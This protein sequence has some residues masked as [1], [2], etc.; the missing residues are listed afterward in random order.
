M[1]EDKITFRPD[2]VRV[3]WAWECGEETGCLHVGEEVWVRN[4][5]KSMWPNGRPVTRHVAKTPWRDPEEK[6]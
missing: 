6:P 1:S 3:E 4:T 5:A 2:E